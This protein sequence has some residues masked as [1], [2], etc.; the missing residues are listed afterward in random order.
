MAKGPK[1]T[2]TD[3]VKRIET[4]PNKTEGIVN[5]D[6]DN[7]Y[8]QRINDIINS[9]GTATLCT[10]IFAK[11]IHGT[12]F[13]SESLA[14]LILNNSKLT[15][16][17]LLF[18][19]GKSLA[20][21]GG[22]AIHVNYNANYQ[23]KSFSII[24]FEDVRFT[25][26]DEKNENRNML[27]IYNDWQK[28]KSSKIIKKDIDYINF[29][30]P[31]PEVIQEEVVAAG[32]WGGYKGQV[33]YFS[34][35]GLEYP[36]APSDSVLEDVQTDSQAKTFKFRNI[37]NGFLAPI[38]F[39]TGVFESP[40]LKDEFVES[41]KD[42]TGADDASTSMVIEEEGE[43]PSFVI[44]KLDVP[45]NERLFEF[46]EESVR[47]NIIRN[48]LIP[49]VL[50]I[51]SSSPLGA[52]SEERREATFQY[53]GITEDLRIFIKEVLKEAFSNSIFVV[54]DFEIG[55]VKAK[56]VPVKDTAE[57]KAN[58]IR[59]MESILLSDKE[60]RKI[61]TNVYNLEPTE[62]AELIPAAIVAEGE[63]EVV[64]VIDEGAKAK[65]TLRGSVGGVTSILAIQTSVAA[66]TTDYTSG[67]AI[68]EIIFGLSSID[69]LRVLG[70]KP[71]TIIN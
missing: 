19:I 67:Q 29:Y 28:V 24:P 47:N 41:L 35:D 36:L 15:G 25:T 57:G 43:E 9:S 39:R 49:P 34:V 2:V 1:A 14:E 62:V 10:A 45:D 59:V 53:N 44:E 7:A 17:K 66:G 69:A 22:F 33:I 68:L 54:D 52:N 16:N 63:E 32:G 55:E 42:F 13:V 48:Y 5:Y 46:T 37:N 70:T 30:N 50:L 31:S 61:L 71:D 21:Y 40:E 64:E 26:D 4:K 65:A 58:I 18:K 8:P 11:Y 60:K 23:K 12:G 6:V 51:Q 27:A 3:V 56:I 20:K 38:I